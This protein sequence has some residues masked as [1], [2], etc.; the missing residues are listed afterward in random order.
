[1]DFLCKNKNHIV[2]VIVFPLVSHKRFLVPD[3]MLVHPHFPDV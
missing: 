1:M 2:A 3:E